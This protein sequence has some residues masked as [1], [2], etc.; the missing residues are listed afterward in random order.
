MRPP[1]SIWTTVLAMINIVVWHAHPADPNS[2]VILDVRDSVSCA[3][4]ALPVC[5]PRS[6]IQEL[7]EEVVR[8][9]TQLEFAHQLA[10][11]GRNTPEDYNSRAALEEAKSPLEAQVLSPSS[12]H[13]CIYYNAAEVPFV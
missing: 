10:H 7:E 4:H 8:L 13:L 2:K 11:E 12:L 5:M 9:K 1:A 6:K 3:H